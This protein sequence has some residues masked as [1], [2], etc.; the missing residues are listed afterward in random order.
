MDRHTHS[1]TYREKLLEHLFVGELLRHAW[2]QRDELLEVAQPEVDNSGYDVIAEAGGVVRHVQLKSA[3]QGAKTAVQK[4]HTALGSKPSGCVVWIY[5]DDRTLDMGPFL[6]FGG[7]PGAPL[8][9]L[10][11]FRVAK[12]TKG[13]SA[14]IKKERPAHRQVP[15]GRFARLETITDV[16][17]ALFGK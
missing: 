2:L 13:D 15:K 3:K 6:F 1:S 9:D 7:H 14:G 8:P 10:S 5:F 17:E 16:Y 4:V 11:S 12:H